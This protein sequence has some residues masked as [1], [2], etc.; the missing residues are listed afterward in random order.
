VSALNERCSNDHRLMTTLY[1]DNS[2]AGARSE[3]ADSVTT[4]IND[5]RNS[6]MYGSQR[7]ESAVSNG[8]ASFVSARSLVG[9]KLTPIGTASIDLTGSNSR[10]NF[11]TSAKTYDRDGWATGK[12]TTAGVSPYATQSQGVNRPAAS[13][14]N[15]FMDQYRLSKNHL[16]H[17]GTV[18]GLLGHMPA[19]T[20]IKS[21]QSS[22]AQALKGFMDMLPASPAPTYSRPNYPQQQS[23]NTS[24]GSSK[25]SN[26][27]KAKANVNALS[28]SSNINTHS[29]HKKQLGTARR[30]PAQK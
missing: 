9:P 25:I 7:F 16:A 3:A 5:Y 26:Q 1:S 29:T 21:F 12:T 14:S 27:L 17:E 19:K 4:V 30:R 11:S 13:S 20:D 15:S 10:F 18:N 8:P 6:S 28:S 23:V 2:D 24:G 22:N